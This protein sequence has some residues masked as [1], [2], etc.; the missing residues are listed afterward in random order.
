MLQKPTI[1]RFMS[2]D[3]FTIGVDQP[4][5]VAHRMMR[6]H[7]IRHL[8]V[9]AEGKLVGMVTERD[10]AFVE[11]FGDADPAV[12]K[13]AEA[14]TPDPYLV[15]PG[16]PLADVA[17]EMATRRLGSAVV[18]DKGHVIGIFTT[19]DALEAL[20][21]LVEDKK[22]RRPVTSPGRSSRSPERPGSP[23]PTR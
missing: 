13:I 3:P 9:L 21:H 22:S 2:R 16:M 14:M 20:W 18:V 19:V 23:A 12:V 8:P 10:L 5:A 7:H 15:G 11:T 6:E 4:L 17:R 1:D